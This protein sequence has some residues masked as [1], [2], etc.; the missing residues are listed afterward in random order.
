MHTGKG[1]Y[2][3]QIMYLEFQHLPCISLLPITHVNVKGTEFS[4]FLGSIC[5]HHSQA[6]SQASTPSLKCVRE[7]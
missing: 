7:R 1:E 5:I 3:T 6:E 4:G 2:T